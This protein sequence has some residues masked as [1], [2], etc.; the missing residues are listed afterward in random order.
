[1]GGEKWTVKARKQTTSE[2][3]PIQESVGSLWGVLQPTSSAWT[4]K[5][6]FAGGWRGPAK[7]LDVLTRVCSVQHSGFA[8][9][10]S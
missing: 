9:S 1:M 3:R 5:D 2:T 7:A 10:V 4:Q 6:P 8:A